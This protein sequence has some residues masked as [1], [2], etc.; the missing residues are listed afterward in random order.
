MR[1]LNL[2]WKD[3]LQVLHD[4]KSLIFLLVM[5]LAFTLLMGMLF[6]S[7]STDPRLRV[8][9]INN[10]PEGMFSASLEEHL[11]ASN[12]ITPVWLTSGTLEQAQS[13]VKSDLY[14]CVLIIPNDFSEQL[15][16]GQD[17]KP[18]LVV[19]P[20]TAVGQLALTAMQDVGGRWLGSARA[21][22]LS[23]QAMGKD[24][25]S[26]ENEG[27]IRAGLD[28][29]LQGWHDPA[30][31]LTVEPVVAGGKT[32]TISG[33]E[34]AS[35]GMIVQFAIFGLT[36]TAIVLVIERKNRCLQRML[37]TPISKAEV[38]I[39]HGLALFLIIFL[40]ELILVVAGQLIFKVNYFHTP[41][42]TLLIMLAL[43]F[44][45]AGMGMFIG[46][47]ARKEEEVIVWSLV[48]MFLFSSLGGAWFPLEGVSS[49]FYTIGHV[50]PA[51]WAMDGFQNVVI[52]HLGLGSALLPALMLFAYGLL[53]LAL[54]VWRLRAD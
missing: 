46:A 32:T 18:T 7:D 53:F 40:Q 24:T 54:A 29:A 8:A 50:S 35:P 33:F 27:N 4:K 45:V 12:A 25:K 11:A 49:T 47:V 26:G 51:A 23:A 5:P 16:A 20:T 42:A 41:M 6:K 14:S 38:I 30:V 28:L 48:A 17:V 22:I 10:D 34:Q 43:A 39:G 19:D 31:T 52:R 9:I 37:S 21:A 15:L 13:D 3:L 36:T 1:I 44:W 2:I